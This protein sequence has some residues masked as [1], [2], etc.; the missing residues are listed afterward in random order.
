VL[1]GFDSAEELQAADDYYGDI[2]AEAKML[3]PLTGV[4]FTS[5]VLD[6][7][8]ER[9]RN[10][11]RALQIRNHARSRAVDATAEWVFEYPEKTDGSRLDQATFDRILDSYYVHR[12][13]D[14]TTGWPTRAKLEELGLSDVADVLDGLDHPTGPDSGAL[15]PGHEETR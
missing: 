6:R 12:G 5:G 7:S 14:L 2:D 9:I 11:D 1:N 8:G 4:D 13:W 15:Q 10:L 3:A